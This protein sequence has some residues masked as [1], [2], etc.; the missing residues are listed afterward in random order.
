MIF[1][2]PR[3]L[4]FFV[5]VFAA[6]WLLRWNAPRKYMLLAASLY[7]SETMSDPG[8]SMRSSSKPSLRQP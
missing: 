2:E 1:S 7:F 5:L 8:S 3:F 4:L 6:H